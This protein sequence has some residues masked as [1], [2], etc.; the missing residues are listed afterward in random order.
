MA[1]FMLL[2]YGFE[3][4]TAEVMEQWNG[5]FESVAEISIEHGGF[6]GGRAEIT[7][8]GVRPLALDK[9]ALTGY[10]VIETESLETAQAVAARNPFV[11]AIRVYEIV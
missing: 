4:P 6:H 2:H 8:A 3:P 9:D 10:S 5:W 11:T 7:G 1:K